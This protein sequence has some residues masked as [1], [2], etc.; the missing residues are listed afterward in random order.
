M[1]WGNITLYSAGEPLRINGIINSNKYTE[2]LKNGLFKSINTHK[3]TLKKINP[4]S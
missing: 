3:L 1:I 4:Y 2:I